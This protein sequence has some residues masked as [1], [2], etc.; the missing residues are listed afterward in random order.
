[1]R[2]T[3]TVAF[4]AS[5]LLLWCADAR[6]GVP[7]VVNE[8][9]DESDPTVDLSCD[10]SADPG[11]QC[12]LRAAIQTANALAG[13]DLVN[14]A[15]PGSG[16]RTIAPGSP[17]PN[18]TNPLVIDGYTQAGASSNTVGPPLPLTTKLR[19]F[20]NGAA[21]ADGSGL[22]FDPGSNGSTVRGL[23]I[24][25]FP[26]AGIRAEAPVTAQ[27]NFLGT[28]AAGTGPRPNTLGFFGSPG[29]VN[30][31]V[32][33]S[34]FGDPNLISGNEAEAIVTNA[35]VTVQGNYIGTERDG[36]APLPNTTD[37]DGLFALLLS[38]DGSDKIIRN[39]IAHSPGGGISVPD[40]NAGSL[41]SVNRMFKNGGLGID[42]GEDGVTPNDN[43]DPD[44]GP[45]AL[46]NFPKITTAKRG[47]STTK[48]EG[49]LNSVPNEPFTIEVFQADGKS[50]QGK[51]YLGGAGFTTDGEGNATFQLEFQKPKEGKYVVTTATRIAVGD[52]G[53]T[54]EFSK[55]RKVE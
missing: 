4:V 9:G 40:P 25:N 41:L 47:Q 49:K 7:I 44:P 43:L 37:D 26:F 46:Q 31:I 33:G 18:V 5:L 45:N 52:L 14:F 28:N 10:V 54:S 1:M 21:L 19:I 11:S 36:K 24:G 12:T 53:A 55:P 50:R 20:L 17:L 34:E 42:L 15:I 16:V 38:G 6:A 23:A 13:V 22:R 8:I 27:G 32:G 29:A 39:I 35:A 51:V 2:S 30:A 48:I 3:R